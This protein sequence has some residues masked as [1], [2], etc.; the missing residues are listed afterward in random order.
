MEGD[1]HIRAVPTTTQPAQALGRAGPTQRKEDRRFPVYDNFDWDNG[2]LHG[3]DFI[4]VDDEGEHAKAEWSAS[5][6]ENNDIST[7]KDISDFPSESLEP[8][9][10]ASLTLVWWLLLI[11][12]TPALQQ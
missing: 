8:G 11:I 7:A 5:K 4:E 12:S 10:E 2:E 6:M 1:D 3:L 9:K